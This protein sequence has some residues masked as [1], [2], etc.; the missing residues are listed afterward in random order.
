ML[1]LLYSCRKYKVWC[2][3]YC[4]CGFDICTR[5]WAG[6]RKSPVHLSLGRLCCSSRNFS[7]N[8]IN[9]RKR[10]YCSREKRNSSGFICR[11]CTDLSVSIWPWCQLCS[12]LPSRK[13]FPLICFFCSS[14]NWWMFL[15]ASQDFEVKNAL[16]L[17]FWFGFYVWFCVNPTFH[18]VLQS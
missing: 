17:R 9:V 16:S 5:N 13:V 15:W 4:R 8:G 11:R 1:Y 6:R 12:G 7:K 3:L 18:L 14:P 10:G 2:I